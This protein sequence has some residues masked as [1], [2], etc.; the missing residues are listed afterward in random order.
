MYALKLIFFYR[1]LISF[2]FVQVRH[3]ELKKEKE[4]ERE[5]L[6]KFLEAMAA[7]S[8]NPSIWN[9]VSLYQIIAS[10]V[11][12]SLCILYQSFIKHSIIHFLPNFAYIAVQTRASDSI[13]NPMQP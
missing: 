3:L 11:C 13:W 12:F 2:S 7:Q 1:Y 6:V 10:P 5:N 4:V 9:K 8:K